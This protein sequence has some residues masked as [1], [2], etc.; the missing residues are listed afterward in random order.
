M[1][2]QV[3]VGVGFGVGVDFGVG[4]GVAVAEVA[5]PRLGCSVLGVIWAAAGALTAG[6]DAVVGVVAS[7]GVALSDGEA[8]GVSLDD[9]DA[10]APATSPLSVPVVRPEL[11][12]AATATTETTPSAT[13][14]AAIAAHRRPR[15]H[16]TGPARLGDISAKSSSEIVGGITA[17]AGGGASM[18][19]FTASVSHMRPCSRQS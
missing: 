11:V 2:R 13:T 16:L 1:M 3:G 18:E 8:R 10:D 7:L 9:G 15:R 12:S 4:V 6:V 5:G 17:A 14:A 19:R